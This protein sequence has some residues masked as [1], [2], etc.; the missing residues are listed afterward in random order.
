MVSVTS[1]V[2]ETGVSP[3]KVAVDLESEEVP[4]RGPDCEEP[5]GAR[6]LGVFGGEWTT[7]VAMPADSGKDGRP[8]EL[9]VFF[10]LS[11]S[12]LALGAG[13]EAVEAAE[14][15]AGRVRVKKG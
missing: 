1:P 9:C 2:E 7:V 14:S 15:A 10:K 12:G 6:G 8:G 4:R 3:K 11:N 5:R 13:R